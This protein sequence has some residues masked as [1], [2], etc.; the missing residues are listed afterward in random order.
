MHGAQA[1]DSSWCYAWASPAA[2]A[3]GKALYLALPRRDRDLQA[4]AARQRCAA[5]RQI[6]DSSATKRQ[7]LDAQ[8]QEAS[9]MWAAA[10]KANQQMA[11]EVMSLRTQVQHA[12]LQPLQRPLSLRL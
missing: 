4:A 8:L 1:S 5:L 2:R 12:A 6:L 9:A 10:T 11:D 7:R 3:T